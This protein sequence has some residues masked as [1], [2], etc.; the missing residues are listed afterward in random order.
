MTMAAKL[1]L[2]QSQNMVMTPQ[3]QQAIKLLH[4][5]AMEL[6]QFI[7]EEL[8]ENPTL[9]AVEEGQEEPRDG[10]TDNER[11]QIDQSLLESGMTINSEGPSQE[12]SEGKTA[13]TGETASEGETASTGETVSAGETVSMD[14]SSA[15]E[16]AALPEVGLDS[17]QPEQANEMLAAM[18]WDNYLDHYSYSLPP[19]AG[20]GRDME[21]G[22]SIEQTLSGP[23]S[24]GEH[25][26]WQVL[27]S[28]HFNEQEK[29][30]AL[31]MLGDLD[32]RGYLPEDIVSLVA[33]EQEEP[34]A[35]VEDILRR[36]QELE[37]LGICARTLAECL[38]VQARHLDVRDD[39]VYTI[40]EHFLPQASRH[41]LQQI[42]RAT[43][44]EPAEVKQALSIIIRLE[45]RPARNY[46]YTPAETI[47]PDIYLHR[48]NH[49]WAIIVDSSG[50]SR[51][52]IS[53]YYRRALEHGGEA[54]N[55]LQER[56]NRARWLVRSIYHRERTLYRV[57]ESIIRFQR[58]FLDTGDVRMLRPLILKD[59]ADE[60]GVNES[61]ISRATAH[62]YVSCDH[63]TLPLKFFFNTSIRRAGQED[64]ASES[65]REYI[66]QL[67][68]TEDAKK[69]LSDQQIVTLLMEQ[70]ITIARRTVAKYRDIMGI[71]SSSMRKKKSCYQAGGVD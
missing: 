17:D 36:L 57:M 9:E 30:I 33:A 24:L 50:K 45:P 26:A 58:P 46:F 48:D 4:M 63:G 28:L 40:I 11:S 8:L 60:L 6:D 7:E 39:L 53:S 2:R 51:L 68:A 49:D 54:K 1:Q 64:I 10:L 43:G 16:S 35:L 65:V 61:T 19:A 12:A 32:E 66:R 56:F 71:L 62:K 55:Y 31:R 23:E 5:S 42:A 70:G 15:D 59:V 44:R 3:L 22:R 20:V 13:S 21:E 41:M 34:E 14:E 52:R 18:D 67:V 25:L 27:V 47:R 37:P 69:P 38:A 29:R